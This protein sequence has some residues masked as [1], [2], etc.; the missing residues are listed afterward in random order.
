M[1]IT[2]FNSFTDGLDPNQ[3]SREHFVTDIDIANDRRWVPY[4]DGVWFQPCHFNCTSGGF[5]VVP[6][7]WAVHSWKHFHWCSH[8]VLTCARLSRLNAGNAF[9]ARGLRD[10]RRF[11]SLQRGSTST[12]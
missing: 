7:R 1:P 6:D 10:I 9:A 11:G 4:A 3:R 8:R 12:F 2:A 5:S